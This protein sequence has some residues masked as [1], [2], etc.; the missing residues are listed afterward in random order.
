MVN[1]QNLEITRNICDLT[2]IQQLEA[3]SKIAD[4]IMP[5]LDVGRRKLIQYGAS[6]TDAT[7]AVIFTTSSTKDTYLWGGEI[8][9]AKD[10]NATSIFQYIQFV[11]EGGA[12]KFFCTL[13]NEP[14]TATSAS[15][16]SFFAIPIKLKRGMAISIISS[17][18]VASIDITASVFIE[19]VDVLQK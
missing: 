13:R 9:T 11:D 2:N 6:C 14:L 7:S 15:T 19:E 4:H 16:S 3:P 5:I 18:A 17:T 8:T 12:S 10:V 1:N